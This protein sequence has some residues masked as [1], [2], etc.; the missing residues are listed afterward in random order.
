MK[1]KRE[2]IFWDIPYQSGGTMPRQT[3]SR[4][5]DMVAVALVVT[6]W[7]ALDFAVAILFGRIVRRP[8]GA[9]SEDLEPVYRRNASDYPRLKAPAYRRIS[10]R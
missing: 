9:P 3:E 8:G 6:L 2:T 4:N 1:V 7:I 10:P 5:L